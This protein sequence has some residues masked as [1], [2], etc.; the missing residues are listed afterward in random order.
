MHYKVVKYNRQLPLNVLRNLSWATSAAQYFAALGIYMHEKERSDMSYQSET[1]RV[2]ASLLCMLML[3]MALP[4][5]LAETVAAAPLGVILT[6]GA[7]NVGGNSAPTGTSLFPGDRITA[8]SDPV[9][10]NFS[11]G[12]RIQMTNAAAT[13]AT[14]N[15]RLIVQASHG[16]FRFHFISADGVQIDAGKYRFVADSNADSKM[17]RAGE[18]GLNQNGEVVMTVSQGEFTM[19]NL[20]TGE[21]SK[22]TAE[23]PL[24]ATGQATQPKAGMSGAAIAALVAGA[25]GGAAAIG[26]SLPKP[27]PKSPSSR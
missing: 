25:G 3:S 16:L 9:L 5:S 19:I 4:F 20:A 11:S 21:Q 1:R 17:A 26:L 18:L 15:Q 23:Q 7:A 22:V 24:L 10:I 6:T 13:F 2:L 8:S 12:R 14:E 27:P